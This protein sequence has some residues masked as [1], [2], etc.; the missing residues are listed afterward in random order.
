MGIFIWEK[1]KNS[2]L[3]DFKYEFFFPDEKKIKTSLH[4]LNRIP[5]KK[6]LQTVITQKLPIFRLCSF[7][8]F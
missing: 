7:Y 3:N 8:E 2:F 5:Q 1:Y 6:D 4:C